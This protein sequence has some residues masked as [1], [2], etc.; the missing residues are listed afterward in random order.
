MN[1]LRTRFL[2]CI[3]VLFAAGAHADII[4]G[5][6]T[7]DDNA[8]ADE[9]I[10]FSSTAVFESYTSDPFSRFS[11]SAEDALTGHDLRSSTIE[12]QSDEYVSVGFTDNLIVNE[13]GADLAIFE[14]F[15]TPEVG[16]ITVE[17]GGTSIDY[18]AVSLGN[19][20][21]GGVSNYV[22]VAYIDLSDFGFAAN[23]TTDYIRAHGSSSEY[24]AFGALNN[25]AASV[26][27]P[28]TAI[29]LSVGLFGFAL[30]RRKKK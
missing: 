9:V 30:I 26:P 27:E 4:V 22:N 20:D 5:G 13:A 2:V 3:A 18:G 24:A 14:M 29:L 12:L 28:S 10:D 17:L 21:L 23:Q 25:Q 1:H 8:F 19:L 15:A 11:V 6:I 16:E 7:F